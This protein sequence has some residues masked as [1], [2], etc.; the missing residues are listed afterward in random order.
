MLSPMGDAQLIADQSSPPIDTDTTLQ[1]TEKALRRHKIV[2]LPRHMIASHITG[3]GKIPHCFLYILLEEGA[4]AVGGLKAAVRACFAGVMPD[5]LTQLE[6]AVDV[7]YQMTLLLPYQYLPGTL[8]VP[9]LTSP[10]RLFEACQPAVDMAVAVI[11]ML[12]E[13]GA[14]KGLRLGYGGDPRTRPGYGDQE[15]LEYLEYL[16][17]EHRDHQEHQVQEAASGAWEHR[18]Q[19]HREHQEY[20]RSITDPKLRMEA[21]AE[22]FRRKK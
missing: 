18:D 9:Y 10:K 14:P 16:D 6:L 15:Y 3:I 1:L 8:P 12:E 19:E 4:G 20:L 13:A 22:I 5:L 21:W 7:L 2:G 11:G 17:Q